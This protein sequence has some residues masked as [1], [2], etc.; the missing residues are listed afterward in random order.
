MCAFAQIIHRADGI[1]P[2]MTDEP[3]K[4]YC[5]NCHSMR[6]ATGGEWV[7]IGGSVVNARRWRCPGCCEARDAAMVKRTPLRG[8]HVGDERKD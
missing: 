2:P 1:H 7:A 4:R 3:D 8:A 5:S 6:T